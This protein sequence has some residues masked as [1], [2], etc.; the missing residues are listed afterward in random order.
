[1]FVSHFF[2]D[3]HGQLVV[4]NGY[5]CGIKDRSQLMLCRSNFVMFCFCRDTKFPQL[6]IQ[7]M[8]ISSNLWFQ[9]TK[10]MIFHFLSFWSRCT[11][12][13]TSA[14][15]QVFSLLIQVFVYQE[16]F[17]F[18][19][20]RCGHAGNGFISQK[21]QHLYC[22]CVQCFHGTEQWSFLIQ[23]LSAVRAECSRNI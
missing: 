20:D 11:K 19:S 16:I 12:Q 3:F 14:E 22:F 5:V 1:M 15:Y 4:V 18:R 7:I 10:V 2:H 17:L 6:Y 13:S 23:C 21:F 8:H 9:G